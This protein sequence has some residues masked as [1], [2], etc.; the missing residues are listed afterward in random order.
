M[1]VTGWVNTPMHAKQ[2]SDEDSGMS[3]AAKS[4]AEGELFVELVT[5]YATNWSRSLDVYT[6]YVR[7]RSLAGNGA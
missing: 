6:P 5:E 1:Q 2:V 3:L 4:E 7:T